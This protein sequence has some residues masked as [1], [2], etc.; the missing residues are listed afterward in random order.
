MWENKIDKYNTCLNT[1]LEIILYYLSFSV[2]QD[3]HANSIINKIYL[4]IIFSS[5]MPVRL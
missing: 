4:S 2:K 5:Y 1:F 3:T